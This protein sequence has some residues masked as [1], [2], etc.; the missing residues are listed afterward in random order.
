ME[1]GQ[2][3]YG[4]RHRLGTVERGKCCQE[5]LLRRQIWDLLVLQA[6][7][8]ML[9]RWKGKLQILLELWEALELQNGGG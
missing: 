9:G 4:L 7:L 1:K 2:L 3:L 8:I 6:Q 5:Y